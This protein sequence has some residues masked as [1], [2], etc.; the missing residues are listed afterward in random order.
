MSTIVSHRLT[1]PFTLIFVVFAFYSHTLELGFFSDD[2]EGIARYQK[3]GLSGLGENYG[4]AFF[5]PFSFLFQAAEVQLLVHYSLIKVLNLL[6]FSGTG[7]FLYALARR[8]FVDHAQEKV[9]SF[10]VALVFLCSPYQ[11]EAINWF[12]S[13]A[14]VLATFFIVWALWILLREKQSWRTPFYFNFLFL[15]ALLNK[16][17]AL[18]LP[19]ILALLLFF[20]METAGTNLKKSLYGSVGILLLY[21]LLRWLVLGELI[22]GYGSAVHSNLNPLVLGQGLAAYVAKFFGFYRYFPSVFNKVFAVI[23]LSLLVLALW[24]GRKKEAKSLLPPLCFLLCF[25]VSLLP[26]LNLETSFLGDIQSDRYGY[27]PSVFF[28]LFLAS[29]L[30]ALKAWLRH[31]AML[32]WL[33]LSLVFLW[34][35]QAIWQEAAVKRD[36]FSEA[37]HADFLPGE[38]HLLNIPDNWKG[39]YLFRH[40]LEEFLHQNYEFMGGTTRA[41]VPLSTHKINV[42]EFEGT[43]CTLGGYLHWKGK[44]PFEHSTSNTCAW[45]HLR[46]EIPENVKVFYYDLSKG[47]IYACSTE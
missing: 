41:S 32:I 12:S 17:I 23:I 14:Y 2:F 20:R 26:V 43:Q 31:G 25:L 36:Q 5:M 11:T 9:L 10:F 42:M 38:F 28:A 44:N 1:I 19:M 6:L 21:F 3:W 35:T 33:S 34:Q 8:F 18:V 4:N 30:Q 39:V 46:P 45:I 15:L 47:K 40:G 13:Q 27:F 24:L 37:L 29:C 7:I 22:G 16:E